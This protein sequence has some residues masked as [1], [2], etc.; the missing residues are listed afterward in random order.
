MQLTG[1]QIICNN[2]TALQYTHYSS[3]SYNNHTS[4]KPSDD[5]LPQFIIDKDDEAET[6]SHTP[7]FSPVESQVE[8]I[9]TTV[10]C[11]PE[12]RTSLYLHT[13]LTDVA[14]TPLKCNLTPETIK[15]NL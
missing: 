14:N 12:R 13:T 11:R 9:V 1:P 15:D 5:Q 4:W 2:V 10:D 7:P 8:K 6:Q 3:G